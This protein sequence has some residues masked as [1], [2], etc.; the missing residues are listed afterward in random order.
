MLP[1]MS[2]P[3]VTMPPRI[4]ECRLRVRCRNTGGN[5]AFLGNGMAGCFPG[6]PSSIIA[7]W[8]S[9][10]MSD[11]QK[12]SCYICKSPQIVHWRCDLWIKSSNV[13]QASPCQGWFPLHV[14]PGPQRTVSFSNSNQDL[15]ITR[16][17]H[18]WFCWISA[19]TDFARLRGRSI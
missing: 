15:A 17:S 18:R 2:S 1:L 5:D 16:V 11:H 12:C 6:L 8:W 3:W 10:H 7:T 4:S 9:V 14:S 19:V 13:A